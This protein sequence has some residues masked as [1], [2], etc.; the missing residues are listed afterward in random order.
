M[1]D[2]EIINNAGNKKIDICKCTHA[3]MDHDLGNCK[4]CICWKIEHG[5]VTTIDK[6]YRT[7]FTPMINQLVK[8]LK[9]HSK[10]ES[11][12]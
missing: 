8:I 4:Y 2:K 11:K 10:E 3:Y 5:Y 7:I 1:T 12:N 9:N 6:H